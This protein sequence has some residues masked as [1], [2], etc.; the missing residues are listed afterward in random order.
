MLRT[1]VPPLVAVFAASLLLSACGKGEKEDGPK[2]ADTA[3]AAGPAVAPA[4]APAPPLSDADVLARLDADNLADSSAGAMAASK[5]TSA[6][7]KDFGRMM[8]KDHHAMRV[9]GMALGT[10]AGIKPVKAPNDADAVT[11]AAVLDSMT[12]LPKGAAWDRFFV[13]HQVV[14]HTKALQFAQDA[15][16]RTQNADLKVLIQKAAPTVQKHLDKARAL[17]GRLGSGAAVKAPM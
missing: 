12:A 15:V 14:G 6:S 11:E 8:L 10:K 2:T 16:N 4:P 17:Q 9:E 3:V 5:G 7:V 1:S 13:E